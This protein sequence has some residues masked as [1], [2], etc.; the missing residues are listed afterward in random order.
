MYVLKHNS[1]TDIH[2]STLNLEHYKYYWS[3]SLTQLP[4]SLLDT[5]VMS[6][7]ILSSALFQR[8]LYLRD[9]FSHLGL[10]ARA[11]LEAPS[12]GFVCRH[13]LVIF[14]A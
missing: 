9:R 12:A 13:L 3:Y 14:A 8:L 2:E 4:V 5:A 11:G 6:L 10:E 7:F 1:G